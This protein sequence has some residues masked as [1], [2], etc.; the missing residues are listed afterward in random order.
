MKSNEI[1]QT[2][3]KK[4][5]VEGCCNKKYAHSLCSKHYRK[6]YRERGAGAK[7][8]TKHR[9][10]INRKQKQQQYMSKFSKTDKCREIRNRYNKSKK[11]V[12]AQNARTAKR[13]AAK[14]SAT[15]S[16]LT[17]LHF[18]HIKLFYEAATAFTRETGE[19]WHVDHIV[20]LKGKNISG[21]HVPWNLQVLP[22]KDNI[23]K[24]NRYV[25]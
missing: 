25:G 2:T 10:L 7:A 18:E 1:E 14:V 11:G 23:A 4:C 5:S 16:W 13:R 20:P 15:P 19:P 17:T 8:D 22:A 6:K 21:L 3:I 9:Q 12:M 24:G